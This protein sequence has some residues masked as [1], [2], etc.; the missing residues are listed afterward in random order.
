MY[1][2]GTQEISEGAHYGCYNVGPK[3][4]QSLNVRLLLRLLLNFVQQNDTHK[5]GLDVK[6]KGKIINFE[7]KGALE[8]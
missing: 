8:K 3:L 2:L 1:I 5:V 7:K 6:R 4:M